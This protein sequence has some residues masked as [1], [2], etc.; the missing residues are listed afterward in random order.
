MIE[1][2]GTTSQEARARADEMSYTAVLWA[3]VAQYI[4]PLCP[5]QPTF[6]KELLNLDKIERPI[7]FP[8]FRENQGG[9]R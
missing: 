2:R 8:F 9:V 1:K 3:F 4:V 6:R 7:A 5:G